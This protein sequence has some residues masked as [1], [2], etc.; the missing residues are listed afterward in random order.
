MATAALACFGKG[1]HGHGEPQLGGTRPVRSGWGFSVS[2]RGARPPGGQ[3]RRS[4][5]WR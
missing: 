1:Q 3:P 4:S 5:R 2:G